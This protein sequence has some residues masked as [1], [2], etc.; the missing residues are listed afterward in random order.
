MEI[1]HLRNFLSEENIRMH[2]GY[3][4]NLKHRYSINE[5]SVPEI[6]GKRMEEIVKLGLSRKLVSELSAL[7]S[8]IKLHECYF[9]SFALSPSVSE[10]L[11][12]YYG[13]E[14]SFCYGML[15]VA[16]GGTGGFLC[17]FLD[18]RGRPVTRIVSPT[19]LKI[20]ESPVLALDLE[21]HA[22]FLDYGFKREEYFR[23]AISHLNIAKLQ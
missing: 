7:A 9:S 17:V 16:K 22:Y 18:S 19:G 5:K 3:M 10:S 11:R 14:N 21:E 13:S 6:R 20:G 1:S 23:A 2:V 15:E 8:E 4:K 12:K